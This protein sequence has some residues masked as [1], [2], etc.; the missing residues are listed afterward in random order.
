[1]AD[2]KQLIESYNK[3][4]SVVLTK[5]MKGLKPL[6]EATK[7]ARKLCFSLDPNNL[8]KINELQLRIVGQKSQL[9]EL[10]S[11]VDSLKRNKELAAYMALKV[12]AEES[13][14]AVKFVDG[15]SKME[16]AFTVADE[17]RVRDHIEGLL[18]SAD[19]ILKTCRNLNNGMTG[20][21]KESQIEKETSVDE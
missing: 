1:M 8:N 3:D 11:K 18:K 21:A 2:V 20:D 13:E 16:A 7:S 9:Q 19:D 4:N 6:E 15:A 5:I 12:R 14:G 10:F 17:R